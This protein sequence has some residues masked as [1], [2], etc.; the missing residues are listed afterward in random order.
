VPA[1]VTIVV[2][3]PRS[4]TQWV[5]ETL[6]AAYQDLALVTHEPIGYAYE[7]RR[8]LRGYDRTQELSQ[9]EAVGAHLDEIA[10]LPD[11]TVYVEAGFPCAAAVPLFYERF[12]EKL[13]VVQLLR[14]PVRTSAS[15]VTH[16]MYHETHREDLRESIALVPWDEGV[17]GVYYSGRWAQMSQ[18][19]K[20]LFYW[21]ELHFY[22][23]E[24]SSRYP[25]LPI[26]RV[27]FEDLIETPERALAAL[28]DFIGLPY[29]AE[30][31]KRTQEKIDRFPGQ[32]RER[33]DAS[34]I[35]DHALSVVLAERFGYEVDLDRKAIRNE[36]FSWKQTVALNLA[37]TKW[38]VQELIKEHV[39]P[40]A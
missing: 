31:V 35:R 14:H 3:T 11:D 2:T 6:G 17:F 34:Q 10:R 1:S 38:R 25:E 15:L 21:T 22:G 36:Y 20:C 24:L 29:R 27:R 37:E 16:G 40:H 8:F 9:I 18:F 4:G 23:L 13:K 32:K 30:M 33:V 19:E 5:A 7:L 39:R 28:M 12:G 26:F